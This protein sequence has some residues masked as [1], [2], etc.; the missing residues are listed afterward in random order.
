MTGW[1][2][3]SLFVVSSLALVNGLGAIIVPLAI[4]RAPVSWHYHH[5]RRRIPVA[6]V[7][8]AMGGALTW[9]IARTDGA[10]PGSAWPALLLL[11]LGL[12]TSVRLHQSNAFPA[13]DFP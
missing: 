11:L 13:I 9:S 6:L 12:V 5:Y 8:V 7:L 3:L 10:L 1:L 2:T 4:H